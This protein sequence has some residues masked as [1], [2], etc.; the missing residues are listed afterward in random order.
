[1][2]VLNK[3]RNPTF[4]LNTYID[5][6]K[7]L[8]FFHGWDPNGNHIHPNDNPDYIRCRDYAL[9]IRDFSFGQTSEFSSF[10]N[11]V[12]VP[13]KIKKLF[14]KNAGYIISEYI[15]KFGTRVGKRVK[16]VKSVKSV[17]SVKKKKKVVRKEPPR[18]PSPDSVFDLPSSLTSSGRSSDSGRRRLFAFGASY[19]LEEDVRDAMEEA[20]ASIH[21]F[22]TNMKHTN[23]TANLIATYINDIRYTLRRFNKMVNDAGGI[24]NLNE[25]LALQVNHMLRELNKA[26][27]YGKKKERIHDEPSRMPLKFYRFGKRSV[28]QF[29]KRRSKITT[30]KKE[31]KLLKGLT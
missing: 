19:Y 17:K 8:A 14:G 5:S 16:R 30:L 1:L 12:K 26:L 13:T 20:G 29:G 22:Y 11:L 23:L 24:E 4:I 31:L 21:T 2:K 18:S 25:D 15:M 10:K 7:I 3:T 6:L 9:G 27:E 28:F